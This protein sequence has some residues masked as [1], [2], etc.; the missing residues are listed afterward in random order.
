MLLFILGGKI[1]K[2]K[3]LRN[4][5]GPKDINILLNAPTLILF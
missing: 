3:V 1:I 5:I 2:K 4:N